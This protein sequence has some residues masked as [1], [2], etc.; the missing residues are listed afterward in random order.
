MQVCAVLGHDGGKLFRQQ[1]ATINPD[2][3]ILKGPYN[4]KDRAMVGLP[5]SWYNPEEWPL[6]DQQRLLQE[7]YLAGPSYS[8]LQQSVLS[9]HDLLLLK[10]RV[11]SF[12]QAEEHLAAAGTPA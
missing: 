3:S 11:V 8:V 5:S 2:A 12:C 6:E 7:K 10:E 1:V 4:D 9:K